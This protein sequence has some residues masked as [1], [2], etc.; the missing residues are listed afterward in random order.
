[1]PR[2]ILKRKGKGLSKTQVKDYAKKIGIATAGMLLLIATGVIGRYASS[3]S[4]P[5][6]ESFPSVPY[7]GSYTESLFQSRR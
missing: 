1:M 6:N 2:R 5:S 3:S 7:H 4:T